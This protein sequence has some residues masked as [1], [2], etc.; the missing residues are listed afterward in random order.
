MGP[1]RYSSTGQPGSQSS[2]SQGSTQSD[3]LVAPGHGVVF[4]SVPLVAGTR[5]R[6]R[7]SICGRDLPSVVRRGLTHVPESAGLVL[8]R[9]RQRNTRNQMKGQSGSRTS[10]IKEGMPLPLAN[11]AS[12]FTSSAGPSFLPWKKLDKIQG[13]RQATSCDENQFRAL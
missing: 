5:R 13:R 4:D 2:C 3:V 10:S 12:S 6:R 1:L 8:Q 7:R 9:Q 11:A